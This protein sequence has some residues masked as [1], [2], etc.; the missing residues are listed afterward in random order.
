MGKLLFTNCTSTTFAN[1]IQQKHRI[2]KSLNPSCCH[3]ATPS[4]TIDL[5]NFFVPQHSPAFSVAMLKLHHASITLLANACAM[6]GQVFV[7]PMSLSTTMH[8]LS[9]MQHS[10]L[11][12]HHWIAPTI[13]LTSHHL[14]L[15]KSHH[16]ICFHFILALCVC[17]T[18]RS[19]SVAS[20]IF[21]AGHRGAN[22]EKGSELNHIVNFQPIDQSS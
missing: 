8:G 10:R 6:V 11:E 17:V 13:V 7:C 15:T 19:T 12:F 14:L 4:Q 20:I 3:G 16:H 5:L 2:P 22:M 21:D 18:V 1:S 9:E